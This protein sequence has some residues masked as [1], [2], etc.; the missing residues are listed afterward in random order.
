MSLKHNML[1]AICF[2]MFGTSSLSSGKMS[3]T[4]TP[5]IK[6][7]N[8]A[9]VKNAVCSHTVHLVL[10]NQHVMSL[11]NNICKDGNFNAQKMRRGKEETTTK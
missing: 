9:S 2:S 5:T 1:G 8:T 4:I 10:D 7:K 6:K 11:T 3:F